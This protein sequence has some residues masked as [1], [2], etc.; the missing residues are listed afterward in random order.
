MIDSTDTP[1]KHPTR[2]LLLRVATTAPA[3]ALISG[4]PA[5]AHPARADADHH[6]VTVMQELCVT[7]HRVCDATARKEEIEYKSRA[8]YPEPPNSILLWQR[9]TGEFIVRTRDQL[10]AERSNAP[11]F[12]SEEKHLKRI[13]DLDQWE[14]AC[15]RIDAQHGLPEATA[16][17]DAAGAIV[18]AAYDKAFD[19]PASVL[20]ALV[21]LSITACATHPDDA[22]RP[23]EDARRGWEGSARRD[24]WQLA[25]LQ[26]PEAT[27]QV[28]ASLKEMY[29]VAVREPSA[30]RNQE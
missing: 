15:R 7:A 1:T 22:A 28:R 18:D 5:L 24:L 2:R 4:I 30:S 17:E 10:E 13:A 8:D 26:N 27:A 29:G 12:I 3:A 11:F 23:D 6:I 16:A 9:S 21:K 14:A 20:G 19:L 25:E